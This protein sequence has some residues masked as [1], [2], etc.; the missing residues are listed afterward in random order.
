[1]NLRD[2][3]KDS[4]LVNQFIAHKGLHNSEFPE[5]TL[6][7][8]GEAIKHNYAIE[9]DVQMLFDG[10]LVVFHDSAIS[11]ATG[12][13]A[14]LS[15]MTYEEIKPL[16]IRKS[17]FGIPTFKEALKFIDGK[18]PILI[19][20]KDLSVKNVGKLEKK[21]CEELEGYKGEF[22]VAS[23]NPY[24]VL[25]FKNNKPE[26]VRGIFSSFYS[27]DDEGKAYVKSPI[28]RAL[29]KRMV[30]NKKIKPDFIGYHHNNLPNRF[31]KKYKNLPI[32]AWT[33]RSQEEYLQVVKYADN[34]IFENFL[35][36]I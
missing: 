28:V 32:L 35:P 9:F 21:L 29:L 36:K 31:V 26:F 24:V 1:M 13:D 4:F 27:N 25:W 12:K 16:K 11:E 3:I 33:V 8:F 10:T 5:N 19:D 30:L 6:G 17:K 14:Y 7:A 20:I 22:A 18:V 34:I 2:N 23:S 15:K